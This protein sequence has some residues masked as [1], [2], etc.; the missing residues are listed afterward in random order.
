M[1]GK[2]REDSMIHIFAQE[3]WHEDAFIVA[4]REGLEALRDALNKA[5]KDGDKAVVELKDL[6]V[7]DGEGFDLA[8]L[9]DDSPFASEFWNRLAVPYSDE[10]ARENRHNALTPEEIYLN[11]RK[12]KN[13]FLP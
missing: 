1:A 13:G 12:N 3:S 6:M 4:N 5:L 2:V 11:R 7:G 9:R 8:I 10:I